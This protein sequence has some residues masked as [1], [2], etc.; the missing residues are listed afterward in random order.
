M[1]TW[2]KYLVF[3]EYRLNLIAF[4]QDYI[5][6]LLNFLQFETKFELWKINLKAKGTWMLLSTSDFLYVSASFIT[7]FRIAIT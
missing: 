2:N 5:E 4:Y 7:F 3:N 1:A 6:L